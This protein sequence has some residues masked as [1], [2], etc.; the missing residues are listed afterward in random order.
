MGKIINIQRFCVDDGPGIRTTVFLSGCGMRCLWCH[1]PESWKL[2]GEMF[3][4]P[5]KCVACG[6]C[7]AICHCHS[8]RGGIHVYDRASC[9]SCGK[10]QS[11]GCGALELSVKEYNAEEVIEQVLKDQ[12]YYKESGGGVTFSGGEPMVQFEFLGELLKLAKASGLHVC[13]ETSGYAET[14]KYLIIKEYVDIFLFDY[15]L[16]NEEMHRKYTGVSNKLILKNLD[17][18]ANMETQIRLRCIIIPTINDTNEHFEAI[19]KIA[20]KYD[21]IIAVDLETY[22]NLGNSKLLH[23]GKEKIQDIPIP[24]EEEKRNY[25]R[26][27]KTKKI[28]NY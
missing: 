12:K 14:E 27:I 4:Y 1:N 28:I 3:Y 16:T 5:E 17:E 25:L 22:H 18:L 11:I 19:G 21:N 7:T 9:I 26:K 6:R 24:S 20:D 10:C 13:L 23:L 8:I 2:S 15:K